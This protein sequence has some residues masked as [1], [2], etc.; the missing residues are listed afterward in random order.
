M[1]TDVLFRQYRIEPS[2]ERASNWMKAGDTYVILDPLLALF[3]LKE[4]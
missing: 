1:I 2:L 3:F 4:E